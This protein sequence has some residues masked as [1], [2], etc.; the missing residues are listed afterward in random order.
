M[1]EGCQTSM[2][3]VLE[4]DFARYPRFAQALREAQVA[5]LEPGEVL[6]MPPMWWHHVESFG[7]NVMVNTRVFIDLIPQLEALYGNLSQGVRLFLR[8][9]EAQRAQARA[10]YQETVFAAAPAA[11]A[12]GAVAEPPDFARHREETRQLVARLPDFLA[13]HLARYYE[14]FVF[15]AHGDPHPS[16]P[17]AFEAMVER[18]AHAPTLFPREG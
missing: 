8:C 2:V 4:P 7:L 11:V 15:Q 16:L 9:P 18:N 14:H 13:K 17:G 5:V 12:S 1:L 3:R 6:I 10:L